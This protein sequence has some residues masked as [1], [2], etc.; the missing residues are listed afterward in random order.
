MRR[1][2]LWLSRE[3]HVRDQGSVVVR[4]REH[5]MH[6]F[7]VPGQSQGPHT[8]EL[9]MSERYDHMQKGPEANDRTNGSR[10]GRSHSHFVFGVH[11][12]L[13]LPYAA[14]VLLQHPN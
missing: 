11:V 2:F 1:I 12:N 4:F 7:E 3:R 8:V 6:E 13:D 10:P 14:H 5:E 9:S